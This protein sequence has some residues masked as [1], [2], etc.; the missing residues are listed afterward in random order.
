MTSI[1]PERITHIN[2]YRDELQGVT[3]PSNAPLPFRGGVGVGR[4]PARRRSWRG[5]TPVPSPEGEGG[6][7][8]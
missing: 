7:R 3:R 1:S 4:I 5:P 2:S 8:S 6:V